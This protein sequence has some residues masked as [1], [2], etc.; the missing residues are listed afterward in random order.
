MCRCAY[1]NEITYVSVWSI[2]ARHWHQVFSPPFYLY[3]L[4]QAFSVNLELTDLANVWLPFCLHSIENMNPYHY[5]KQNI[6]IASKK[7]MLD[8]LPYETSTL[9]TKLSLQTFYFLASSAFHWSDFCCAKE[10]S[11]LLLFTSNYDEPSPFWVW[12]IWHF[13]PLTMIFV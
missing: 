6:Y 1:V 12:N 7:W 13:N 11:R 2:K 5:A 4:R 8:P 10:R 3:F 9:S